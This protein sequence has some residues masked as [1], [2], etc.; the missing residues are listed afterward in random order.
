LEFFAFAFQGLLL[1]LARLLAKATDSFTRRGCGW[2]GGVNNSAF[3]HECVTDI[4]L[5]A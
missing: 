4:D 3:F 5:R 2:G 1:F